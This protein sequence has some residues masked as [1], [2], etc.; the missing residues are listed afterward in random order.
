[1][2]KALDQRFSVSLQLWP[3]ELGLV[4][5]AGFGTTVNNRPDGEEAREP[6]GS[7][8]RADAQRPD[9]AFVD[10]PI[11]PGQMTDA[12][13]R[14]LNEVLAGERGRVLGLCRT[15]GRS[16]RRWQRSHELAAAGG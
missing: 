6:A 11:V 9:I 12:D 7:E 5:E 10:I 13:A 4:P 8:L 16:T 1:M 14:A 2:T 15:G 3:G